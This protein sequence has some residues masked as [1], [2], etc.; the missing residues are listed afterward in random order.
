[1]VRPAAKKKDSKSQKSLLEP[2]HWKSETEIHLKEP[3]DSF[4]CS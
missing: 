4:E 2:L 1:M 3:V